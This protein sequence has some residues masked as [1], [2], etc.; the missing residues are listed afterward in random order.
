MKTNKYSY[1]WIIQGLYQRWEDLSAY[2]SLRE[3]KADLKAY[4]V[5]EQGT[6]RVIQRRELRT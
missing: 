4:R 2:E 3:A 5:N 6:F 1:L